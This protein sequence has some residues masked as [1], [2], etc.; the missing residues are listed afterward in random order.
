MTENADLTRASL[1]VGLDLLHSRL[2]EL[3]NSKIRPIVYVDV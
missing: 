2:P 3:T 1:V